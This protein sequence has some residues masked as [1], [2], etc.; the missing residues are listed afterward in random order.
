[1]VDLLN[2]VGLDGFRYLDSQ[3]LALIHHLTIRPINYLTH[4]PV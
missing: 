1:M 3:P 2:N 4:H